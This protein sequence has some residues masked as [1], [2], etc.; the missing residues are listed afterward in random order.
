[1]RTCTACGVEVEEG[2]ERCPLCGTRLT[3]GPP[4]PPAE[5][6]ERLSQPEPA[7]PESSVRRWLWEVISLLAVTAAGILFAIDLGNGFDVTWSLYPLSAIAFLWICA[8]SAIALAKRPLAL[9]AALAAAVL[10]FLLVLELLTDGRPWFLQ[11]AVPLVALAIVVGAGAWAVVGRLRLPPLSAIAV[12]VLGC[13]LAGVGVEYI[14]NR[15]LPLDRVVSWSLVSL[16]CSISLFFAL[17]L[18]NKRLKE[19]H[20]DIRR[21]FHL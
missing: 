7:V 20:S 1:M 21:M 15:Y 14:L 17:L 16:A 3:E 19:R 13:G 12:V 6:K 8:T 11:L 5:E 9:C 4:G 10:A 2:I 18:V